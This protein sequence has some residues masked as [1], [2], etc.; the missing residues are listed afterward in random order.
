MTLGLSLTLQACESGSGT[1]DDGENDGT[2]YLKVSVSEF[3]FGTRDVG[4]S[5]TQS[6]KLTNQSADNYP[7]DG[8][9]VSGTSSSE[10]KSSYTGGLKTLEPGEVLKVDLTF[11][12]T[13]SGRKYSTLDIEHGIIVKASNKQNQAEQ[14]YYKAKSLEDHQEY[15]ES[16]ITYQD[17]IASDPITDNKRRA[18]I[19]V[20]ILTESASHGTNDD[21]RLYTTA[22]DDRETSDIDTAMKKLDQLSSKQP[23]SYLADDALYM[24]GYI[25]LMD[26]LNYRA[27]YNIM[28]DLRS[29]YPDSSY[30]DTA[31]YVEAI[32]LKELG[33]NQDAKNKFLELR[34]RHTGMTLELFNMEW[35]KDNYVS[36]LWFDRSSQGLAELS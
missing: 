1:D 26:R 2:S 32:A 12:P 25:Q 24:R 10:F 19:K 20:P 8:I 11:S 5:A 36:R 16:L 14:H 33:Q 22:L 31:L 23:D 6:I 15:D 17:Y 34:Q 35:P 30:Y 4:S 3:Y 9:E 13:S 28:N 21:L 7:I 27:A 18:N 29:K